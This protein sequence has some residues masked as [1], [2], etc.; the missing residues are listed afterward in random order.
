MWVTTIAILVVGAVL[1]F[2]AIGRVERQRIARLEALRLGESADA[3]TALLGVEPSVCSNEPLDHLR[4]SFPEGWPVAAVDVA[5]EE[6]RA[7]TAERWVYPVGT[8]T[9]A[10]CLGDEPRTE[11]GV[12]ADSSVLWSISVLGRS[13]LQLPSGFTP[14]GVELPV[15]SS[16]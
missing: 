9:V 4:G 12:A 16:N 15:G 6:L 8:S 7:E 1:V 13:P 11:I 10:P 3:V 2:V 14:A 5:L